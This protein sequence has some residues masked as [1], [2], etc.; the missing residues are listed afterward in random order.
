MMQAPSTHHFLLVLGVILFGTIDT[1]SRKATSCYHIQD[2]EE[3][4]KPITQSLFMF[5]GELFCFVPL[6]FGSFQRIILRTAKHPSSNSSPST[7]HTPGVIIQQLFV[8][9][10][11]TVL[12]IVATILSAFSLILLP[13]SI[14]QIFKGSLI[15]FTAVF[16][17]C[18]LKQP[19]IFRQWLGISLVVFG[20]FLVGLS[21]VLGM[22]SESAAQTWGFVLL[23][24]AQA[25]NSLQFIVEEYVIK[26]TEIPPLTILSFEGLFGTCLMIAVV[27]PVAH[28]I[29]WGSNIGRFEDISMGFTMIGHC[30]ILM[31]LL[32]VY[33]LSLGLF[34]AFSLQI[35]SVFSSV[36]RV[37]LNSCVPLSVWICSVLLHW[38]S[39]GSF[40]EPLYSTWWLQLFGFLV[41]VNGTLA[42]RSCYQQISQPFPQYSLLNEFMM[43]EAVSER[44]M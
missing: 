17:R 44:H 15:L 5:L 42:Y 35:A 26:Q 16:S 28:F 32:F 41:I 34:N 33:A 12:D 10:C 18:F 31:L 19:I 25:C 1:I 23:L 22:P 7:N 20:L 13:A 38:L 3:F 30:Q 2:N 8:V 11:P 37:L 39:N 36:Y 24:L 21:N 27:F 6:F 40:G 29:H 4:C 14:F 9:V 43:N